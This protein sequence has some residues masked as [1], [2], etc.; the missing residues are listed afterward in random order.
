MLRL[1]G[2]IFVSRHAMLDY[3][4]ISPIGSK[5]MGPSYI[6]SRIY[7]CSLPSPYSPPPIHVGLNYLAISSL[8]LCIL[9]FLRAFLSGFSSATLLALVYEHICRFW[10]STSLKIETTSSTDILS[11]LRPQASSFKTQPQDPEGRASKTVLVQ[12]FPWPSG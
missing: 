6:T 8:S 7:T 11:S 12:A 2:G 3:G 4:T 1:R 9:T 5:H 10:S